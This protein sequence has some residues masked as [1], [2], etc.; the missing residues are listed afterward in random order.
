[1]DSKL[2][3]GQRVSSPA[4]NSRARGKRAYV[5]AIRHRLDALEEFQGFIGGR[6]GQSIVLQL[7]PTRAG[8]QRRKGGID[9]G[10]HRGSEPVVPRSYNGARRGVTTAAV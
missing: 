5:I 7:W 10:W 3:T 4:S 2:R 6:T 8:R 9:K 1:M